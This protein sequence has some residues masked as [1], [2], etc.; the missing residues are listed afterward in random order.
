MQKG[1]IKHLSLDL[2]DNPKLAM[3]S[4]TTGE[5]IEEL[6]ADMKAVGLIEP[7]VVRPV[8][9]RY[10]I[11]AGHRR[12]T[13]GKLLNWGTIESKIV[14]ADDDKAFQMRLIENVSRVD[15]NPVDEAEYIGEIMN[16][17]ELDT[18]RISSLLH[19]SRSWVEERLEVFSMEDQLKE[20]LRHKRISLGASL[21][22]NRIEDE[23]DR[24][25]YINYASQKG[26]SVAG[27]KEWCKSLN[28]RINLSEGQKIEIAEKGVQMT[29]NRK[30][31]SC[32]RCNGSLYLDRAE[33][34]WV[35]PEH[36]DG[37]NKIE[38]EVPSDA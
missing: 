1:E 24:R 7:I 33:S 31:V 6:M 36:C 32:A 5:N 4:N 11:I 9:D 17:H 27:A 18:E 28:G 37:D 14:Q 16:K 8:G 35:H 21:W 29:Y 23:K 3:R 10:E 38:D 34:V 22:L 19:R 12:T 13:A 20:Y 26:V 2:I 25:Y 30:L 15:V